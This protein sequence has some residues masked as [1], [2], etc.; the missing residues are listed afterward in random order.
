MVWLAPAD[1]IWCV[2]GSYRE[3]TS[4]WLLSTVQGMAG[5]SL[6]K[7]GV[8]LF[9]AKSGRC[10]AES[11]MARRRFLPRRLWSGQKKIGVSGGQQNLH[12]SNRWHLRGN[13][14]R[15]EC[16]RRRLE[17]NRRRLEGNR[18][19]WRVTDGG[20]RVTDGGWRVTDGGW[21]VTNGGWRQSAT[22]SRPG[23]LT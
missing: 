2:A 1:P 13:R 19:G 9:P 6:P 17:G 20:W 4:A 7:S 23:F 10:V 3:R 18:G 15:L 12:R 8:W 21:R 14:Q 22:G 16:S 5:W 11:G